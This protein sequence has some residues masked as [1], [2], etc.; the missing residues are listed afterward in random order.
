M[1]AL[2][3]TCLRLPVSRECRFPIVDA[4][5]STGAFVRALVENEDAGKRLLAY[6]SYLSVRE[7]V[8]MWSRAMGKETGLVEVPTEVM[9]KQFGIPIEVLDGPAYI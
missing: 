5:E 9:H 7:V 4:T 8:E 6:D 1:S 2:G 3:S